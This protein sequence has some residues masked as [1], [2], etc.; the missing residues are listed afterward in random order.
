MSIE[1]I[2][3]AIAGALAL[4]LLNDLRTSNRE[5]AQELKAIRVDLA[6]NAIAVALLKARQGDAEAKCLRQHKDDEG[7]AK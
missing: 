5:A 2:V 3:L 1:E 6:N 4:G 7:A